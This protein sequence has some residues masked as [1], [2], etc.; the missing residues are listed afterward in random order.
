MLRSIIVL[1]ILLAWAV[2]SGCGSSQQGVCIDSES[3]C[4]GSIIETCE[5]GVY[6]SG[7]NC[8]DSERNCE[9][10]G[11]VAECV[12]RTPVCSAGQSRCSQD[13]VENC[14]AGAWTTGQDCSL[15]NQVCEINSNS[16]AAEC[17]DEQQPCENGKTR[18]VNDTIE[19]CTAGSWLPGTNCAFLSQVCEINAT[20]G[21]AE[22]VIPACS[23]GATRCTDNTI[24]TCSAEDWIA[25]QDCNDTWQ[26]CEVDG[27]SGEAVCV[28]LAWIHLLVEINDP[29][30]NGTSLMMPIDGPSYGYDAGNDLFA[31]QYGRSFTEPE[32]ASIWYLDGS[33]GSHYKT[34]LTGDVFA[35]DENLCMGEDWC[36]FISFDPV[37][38]DWL[39][40]APSASVMMWVD[41]SSNGSLV[42]VSGSQ[43]P[44]SYINRNHVFD[45][46]ERKL[47]LYG[48]VG[49]SSFSD[50]VY[51]LDIDTAVW[52][53]AVTGLKQVFE[54]CLVYDSNTGWLYSFGGRQTTDGGETS[55]MLSSYDVIDTEL[56]TV[57]TESLPPGIVA[58]RA[59]NCAFDPGRNLIYVLGG[60]VINDRFNEILNEYH[61]DLWVLD[62]D[63]NSW[64]NVMA[65][66][67]PGTYTEPDQ[68]GDQSFIGDVRKPN[69]GK[70]RGLMKYDA[71]EDRLIIMGEVPIFTHVQAY[72]LYL[73]GLDDLLQ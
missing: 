57:T 22:C 10:V 71:A 62:L 1:E 73:D 30:V 17:V 3:R 21:E 35:Q 2:F 9:I 58:R 44:D 18:C 24:E 67:V 26:I 50:T 59:M 5:G 63:D 29:I 15:T 4:N 70:E 64:T 66:T 49:P 52:S 65:D 23:D 42:W 72:F 27:T 40:V 37:A 46:N 38:E 16:Q 7:I 13:V 53:Q 55:Q 33:S 45:W 14:S 12:E 60:S 43:Q 39:F 41:S 11:G 36:Q 47:F 34:V 25:G 68:Y 56:G 32:I 28:G 31:T 54:N 19:N 69:F 48:A 20:S 8:N 51:E 6:L 61:N